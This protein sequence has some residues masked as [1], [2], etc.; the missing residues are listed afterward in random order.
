MQ[1]NSPPT[2][3]CSERGAGDAFSL[4]SSSLHPVS[5]PQAV[6]HG[7]GW[8]CCGGGGPQVLSV[9][10]VVIVVGGVFLPFP[11]LV[12]SFPPLPPCLVPPSPL[13]SSSRSP[14][15]SLSRSPLLSSSRSPSS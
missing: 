4:S 2:H 14:S 7:G 10:V 13:L 9:V 12:I 3:V 8:G 11:L 5:T 6:A 1:K 15:S